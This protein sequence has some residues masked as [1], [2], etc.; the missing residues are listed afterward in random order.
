MSEKP[1]P[2]TSVEFALWLVKR[3]ERFNHLGP[4]AAEW[5]CI[6]RELARVSAL[7]L[8]NQR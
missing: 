7:T 4:T 1:R 5:N 8:A 6:R 3:A 2:I